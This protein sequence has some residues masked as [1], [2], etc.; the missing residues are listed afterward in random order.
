MNEFSTTPDSNHFDVIKDPLVD[1]IRLENKVPY[2]PK[3]KP[4]RGVSRVMVAP[5]LAD[6][7]EAQNKSRLCRW[8]GKCYIIG[9]EKLVGMAVC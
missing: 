7:F 2:P 3:N 8:L 5:V 1:L 4:P 9:R 6:V